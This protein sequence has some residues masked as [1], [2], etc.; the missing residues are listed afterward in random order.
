MFFDNE[1]DL[2]TN[3]SGKFI[4]VHQNTTRS[5]SAKNEKSSD[6]TTYDY[7]RRMSGRKTQMPRPEKAN[8]ST[9]NLNHEGMIDRYKLY[10]D[11][12]EA[13]ANRT[14]TLLRSHDVMLRL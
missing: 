10:N 4:I 8:G 9:V 6:M 2:N 14:R 13:I 5:E 1:I 12:D 3:D 7:S 11:D